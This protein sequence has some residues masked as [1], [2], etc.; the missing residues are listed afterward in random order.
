MNEI[1]FLIE[2]ASEGGYTAKAL[3]NVFSQ[4]E[5]LLRKPR[6]T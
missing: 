4:K 3:K 6:R 1:I 5:K 2:E